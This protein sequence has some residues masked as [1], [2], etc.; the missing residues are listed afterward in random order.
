MNQFLYQNG[1]ADAGAAEKSDLAAFGIR[2]QKVDDLNARL[3]NFGRRFLLGKGRRFAVN[4]P[5][6]DIFIHGCAAVDRVAEHAEQASE[7]RGTDGNTNAVSGR[8]D[9]KPAR[10]SFAS[11]KHNA[12]HGVMP[13]VLCYLHMLHRSVYGHGQFFVQS[14]ELFVFVKRNVDDRTRYFFDFSRHEREPPFC[15]RQSRISRCLLA[16]AE[17]SV[18][19]CV[20][21]LCRT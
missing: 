11:R 19:S 1:F 13:D 4:V 9:R 12:A 8:F 6:R 18:I 17:I 2:L 15:F 16:P 7:G 21:A 5:T 20:M 10:K 14:R 3:Q